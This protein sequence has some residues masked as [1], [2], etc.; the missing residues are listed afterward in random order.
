MKVKCKDWIG[1]LLNLEADIPGRFADG[2]VHIRGY[3]VEF[4]LDSGECVRCDN[5]S[6]KDIEVFND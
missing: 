6:D 5:V 4:Q 2:K 3:R 1:T